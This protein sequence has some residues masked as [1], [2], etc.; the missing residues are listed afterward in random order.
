M[1]VTHTE[2]TKAAFALSQ[3]NSALAHMRELGAEHQGVLVAAISAIYCWH[4]SDAPVDGRTLRRGSRQR[5][6]HRL[7][8]ASDAIVE[9]LFADF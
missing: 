7:D 8:A 3:M 1:E 2:H 6:E 5:F 9:L 4:Q